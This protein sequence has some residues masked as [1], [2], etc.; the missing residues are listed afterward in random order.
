M[1][2]DGVYE[3]EPGTCFSNWKEQPVLANNCSS[4]SSPEHT[5]TA[6]PGSL[7]GQHMRN[8]SY[9]NTGSK[10]RT[11]V[12]PYSLW[13]L[14]VPDKKMFLQSAASPWAGSTQELPTASCAGRISLSSETHLH[15]CTLA[16]A[17]RSPS[18]DT[19][20]A[21][22]AVGKTAHTQLALCQPGTPCH[23]Q[24][25]LALP[26]GRELASNLQFLLLH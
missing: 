9:L 20:P 3:W 6:Q 10:Y 12:R 11:A 18:P 14:S 26:H 8:E 24:S 16:T 13:Q 23:R 2:R 25:N 17:L 4:S 7:Q 21:W 19:S 1:L 5:N 22:C 15:V